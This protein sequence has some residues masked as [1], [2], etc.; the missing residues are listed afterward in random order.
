MG[1]VVLCLVSIFYFSNVVF[2]FVGRH[3]SSG[4]LFRTI[5]RQCCLFAPRSHTFAPRAKA[6]A[7]RS[8]VMDLNYAKWDKVVSKQ[9]KEEV[10]VRTGRV[11]YCRR[12]LA[13]EQRIISDHGSIDH[14]AILKV[15]VRKSSS[16]LYKTLPVRGPHA[17]LAGLA[18][19]LRA[20]QEVGEDPSVAVYRGHCVTVFFV[21]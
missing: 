20:M 3:S 11:C 9:S 16:W 17:G 7:L 15:C 19:Q 21:M 14:D 5:P 13:F 10:A 2:G 18:E 4:C 8:I 12:S 6:T 1:V